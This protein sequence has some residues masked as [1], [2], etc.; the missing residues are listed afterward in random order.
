MKKAAIYG[1]NCIGVLT[2][3]GEFKQYDWELIKQK[4]IPVFK[5]MI[6]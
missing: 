3:W 5:H 1:S 4:N 2:E 6:S